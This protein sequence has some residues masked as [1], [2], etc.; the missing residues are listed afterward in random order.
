MKMEIK[1]GNIEIFIEC[2]GEV[3]IEKENI[4]LKKII[5]LV[6]IISSSKKMFVSIKSNGDWIRYIINS[7]DQLLRQINY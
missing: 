6:P 2:D 1:S 4:F 7:D 5:K 3:E